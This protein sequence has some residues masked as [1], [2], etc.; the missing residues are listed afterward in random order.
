MATSASIETN[1]SMYINAL[2]MKYVKE[3]QVADLAMPKPRFNQ[4]K[5]VPYN[6]QNTNM[7]FASMQY[8]QRYNLI[9]GVNPNVIKGN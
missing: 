3:E 9:P 4:T 6:I 5:Q 7:S 2:A 1:T 8:L